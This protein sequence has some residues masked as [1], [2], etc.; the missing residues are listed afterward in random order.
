MSSLKPKTVLKVYGIKNCDTMKK[1][2]R[3][4]EENDVAYEFIDYKKNPPSEELING[5]LDS[6]ALEKVVNKRGTTFRK[7]SEEEKVH[8]E[9]AKTAV[10]LLA[11]HSSMI[12]RPLIVYPSGM[13]SVGLDP[14]VILQSK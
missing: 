4:L 13:I 14:E 8:L 10:P 11:S 9:D 6:I 2:F 1:T 12:K 7:L 3:L 5:F